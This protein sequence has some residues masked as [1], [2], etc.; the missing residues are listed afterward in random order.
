MLLE[1]L[2][3]HLTSYLPLNNSLLPHYYV[4]FFFFL[5]IYFKMQSHLEKLQY[6]HITNKVFPRNGHIKIRQQPTPETA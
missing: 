6:L 1:L 5:N 2:Y 4:F 3:V